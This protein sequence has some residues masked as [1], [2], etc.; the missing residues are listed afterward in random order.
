[1]AGRDKMTLK[2]RLK[3]YKRN[4]FSLFLLILVLLAVG[5]TLFILVSIVG[6]ILIK[7]IPY[8]NPKLFEWV[9]TTENVSMMPAIINTITMTLLSLCIAAPLGIFSSSIL[10]IFWLSLAISS[11][12]RFC[13]A[14]NTT[15]LSRFFSS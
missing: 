1:M 3:T 15:I 12:E 11:S 8:I 13:I 5:I 2:Q 14:F 7:G 9:Y 6:Y 4:P 10:H